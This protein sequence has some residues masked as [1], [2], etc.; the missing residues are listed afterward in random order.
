MVGIKVVC[1][2]CDGFSVVTGLLR[3]GHGVVAVRPV[4]TMLEGEEGAFGEGSAS[5]GLSC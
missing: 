2:F 5:D 3:L 4:A 1:R